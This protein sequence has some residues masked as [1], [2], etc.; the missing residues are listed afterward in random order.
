MSLM[1]RITEFAYKRKQAVSIIS[2]KSK[3][4]H[5]HILKC[6]IYHDK[7]NSLS[8]W[9][10]EIA[11]YCKFCDNVSIKTSSGKLSYND[12]MNILLYDLGDAK[13]DVFTWLDGF[14]LDYCSYHSSTHYPEFIIDDDLCQFIYSEVTRVYKS[15]CKMMSDKH[16]H[17]TL[18]YKKL[19]T[20]LLS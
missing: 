4:I 7:L 9:I 14:Y 2:D 17:S 20:E 12:Y 3:I 10:D 1:I 5:D 16:N 18:E 15:I 13:S 19:L 6:L 11:S 8:H